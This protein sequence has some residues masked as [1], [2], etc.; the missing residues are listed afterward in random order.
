M[1][2]PSSSRVICRKAVEAS[3]LGELAV[4]LVKQPDIEFPLGH[5]GLDRHANRLAPIER[6]DAAL[7]HLLDR[8]IAHQRSLETADRRRPRGA[9]DRPRDHGNADLARLFLGHELD[10]A[11]IQRRIAEVLLPA[12]PLDNDH[13]AVLLIETPSGR[14]IEAAAHRTRLAGRRPRQDFRRHQRVQLERRRLH[15][16]IESESAGAVGQHDEQK[17]ER[18]TSAEAAHRQRGSCKEGPLGIRGEGRARDVKAQA[19]RCDHGRAAPRADRKHGW[20]PAGGRQVRAGDL[21]LHRWILIARTGGVRRAT[22][23]HEVGRKRQNQRRVVEAGQPIE[24]GHRARGCL[25]RGRPRLNAGSLEG[26]PDRPVQ[27]VDLGKGLTSEGRQA[28][29]CALGIG[30]GAHGQCI[31][32]KAGGAERRQQVNAR[33][34]VGTCLQARAFGREQGDPL[35]DRRTRARRL[36]PHQQVAYGGK[37]GAKQRHRDK[38]SAHAS[39]IVGLGRTRRHTVFLA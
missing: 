12:K 34:T 5:A 27:R 8:P 9:H 33:L 2:W 10:R 3:G 15:P 16:L 6:A 25:E 4:D 22:R 35:A 39:C 19:L 32:H 17:L 24:F 36:F 37:G 31:G 26:I 20:R 7:H 23:R 13:A 28:V 29:E 30:L 18:H 38:R 11:A 21:D 1:A 14:R